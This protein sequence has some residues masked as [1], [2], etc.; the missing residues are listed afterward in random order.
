MTRLLGSTLTPTISASPTPLRGAQRRATG[1]SVFR[2]PRDCKFL[3]RRGLTMSVNQKPREAMQAVH[4]SGQIPRFSRLENTGG[5][6]CRSPELKQRD[7]GP[8]DQGVFIDT[9][10]GLLVI[11]G[12]R[13]PLHG[14]RGTLC[15]ESVL[16]RECLETVG[17]ETISST[18]LIDADSST[19]PIRPI[20][21]PL[22]LVARMSSRLTP[23]R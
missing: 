20:D 12:C 3:E 17:G 21:S 2:T 1:P 16:R 9:S 4:L 22:P 15:L 14:L 6:F 11:L 23:S 13:R 10:L 5:K 19:H 18:R 7:T 8:D